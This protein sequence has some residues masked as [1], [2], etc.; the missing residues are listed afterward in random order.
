MERTDII[1]IAHD[2]EHF[3]VEAQLPR[4]SDTYYWSTMME[5]LKHYSSICEKCIRHQ[6]ARKVDYPAQSIEVG[7][8]FDCVGMDCVFGLPESPEGLQKIKH[9]ENDPRGWPHWSHM[10]IEL[11]Y[12]QVLVL[13]HSS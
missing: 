4:I 13:P 12:I 1:K 10:L 3:S 8:I 2:L 5:D 6:T 11:R 9:A 7:N